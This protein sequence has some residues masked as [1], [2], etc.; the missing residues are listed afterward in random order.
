MN[1]AHGYEMGHAAEQSVSIG[2]YGPAQGLA[3]RRQAAISLPRK[4]SAYRPTKL[5]KR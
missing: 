3:T 1:V 5:P 4:R 2:Q